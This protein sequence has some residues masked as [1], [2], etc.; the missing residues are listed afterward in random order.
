MLRY[1][2]QDEVSW[3]LNHD[4][5]W[6]RSAIHPDFEFQFYLSIKRVTRVFYRSPDK[7]VR[8]IDIA[9]THW[10]GVH[11]DAVF[12]ELEEFRKEVRP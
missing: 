1:I 8:A 12:N 9:E 10:P 3:L 7:Q 5:E 11:Q 4:T 6:L 2:S